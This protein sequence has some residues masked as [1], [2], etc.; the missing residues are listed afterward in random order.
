[1]FARDRRGAA[2]CDRPKIPANFMAGIDVAERVAVNEPYFLED[3]DD[4]AVQ[5]T[6]DA[7]ASTAQWNS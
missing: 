2:I 6:I 1:M 5:A 7:V 3:P 4:G